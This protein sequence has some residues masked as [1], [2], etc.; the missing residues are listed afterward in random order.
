MSPVESSQRITQLIKNVSYRNL[1]ADVGPLNLSTVDMKE[2]DSLMNSKPRLY[3]QETSIGA[4]LVDTV[5]VLTL[6]TPCGSMVEPNA[7]YVLLFSMM[8]GSKPRR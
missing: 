6:R 2:Y 7:K 5:I 8:N 1:V 4:L 3:V